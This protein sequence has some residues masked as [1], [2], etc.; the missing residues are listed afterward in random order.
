VIAGVETAVFEGDRIRL[1]RDEF[2]PEAQKRL[3]EW[4]AEHGSKLG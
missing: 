2:D 4:M 1:L 3:G